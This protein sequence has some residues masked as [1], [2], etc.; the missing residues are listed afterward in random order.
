MKHTL[1][2]FLYRNFI[3]LAL[4]LTAFVPAM[5]QNQNKISGN[6]KSEEQKSI[7]GTTVSLLR[8]ADSSLVKMA[9]SDANGHFEFEN[10]SE[11]SYLLSYTAVGYQKKI[12]GP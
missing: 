3:C 1:Q 11:G 4:F 6:I 8:A 10:I 2:S 9:V 7:N 5:A 12:S